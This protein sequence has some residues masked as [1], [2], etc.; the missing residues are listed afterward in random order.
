MTYAPRITGKAD[1]LSHNM[2]FVYGECGDLRGVVKRNTS[3]GNMD[4][5]I[6]KDAMLASKSTM[7]KGNDVT[8]EDDSF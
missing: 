5:E 8:T 2:E 1:F 3:F 4:I 7:L 6:L